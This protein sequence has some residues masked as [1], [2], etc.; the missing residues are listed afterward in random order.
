[1]K[2]IGDALGH[3]DMESTSIYLRLNVDDLRQAAL[4]VP[5]ATHS[6]TLMKLVA[7]SSIARIR[8]ATWNYHLP[9]HFHSP[10]AA[11]LQRFLGLMRGMGLIYA[12]EAG[13]LAHWDH[14]IARQYPQVRKVRA[15]MFN[16][17][18]RTLTHVT[19]TG[20]RKYQRIVRKFLL[21]HARDHDGTFIPD[22]LTF[23]KPAPVV[24]PR[25]I[26]ET[27]MGRVLEAARKLPPSPTNPLRSETYR[28]GLILLF[29]CG[30]RQGELRRLKLGDIEGEQTVLHIRLSKFQKSRLV[31][32]SPTVTAELKLY[33]RQRHQKKV[34]TTP[35]AFL[36]WSGHRSP[37]VYCA[38][39]LADV[40]SQLC[41]SSQVLN[42]RGHPPRLHDL[43][44]SF[45]VNALQRWYAEG[46]DVQAKLPHLAAYLGHVN[47]NKT[48]YYLKLTPELRQAANRRF[49]QHFAPL[50][51]MGGVA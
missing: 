1:M 36:M 46:S 20:S 6:S 14:F 40:W 34:P 10:F 44:H 47:A 23:P 31:P 42:P 30:L 24:S 50:L 18:A 35:D 45:A 49:H 22:L 48:H 2:T 7:V 27:E 3:R 39:A 38:Q 41:V 9:P 32:L 25:L 37:E 17:W 8:P 16:A 5:P 33:L 21:F 26:S 15:E 13:V 19:S 12:Q 28:M 4:P 29:C 11:S 43:R 51:T